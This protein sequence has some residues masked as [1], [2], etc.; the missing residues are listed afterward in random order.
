[1]STLTA[2]LVGTCG[3]WGLVW[4]AI[5]PSKEEGVLQP[6][7]REKTQSS[8]GSWE[9]APAAF[10]LFGPWG[11]GE[12]ASSLCKPYP[13]GRAGF[14]WRRGSGGNILWQTS[15]WGGR[16]C[17]A[18]WGLQRTLWKDWRKAQR[19]E[20]ESGAKMHKTTQEW[21]HAILS[22][23]AYIL[24]GSQVSQMRSRKLRG[25]VVPNRTLASGSGPVLLQEGLGLME[26]SAALESCHLPATQC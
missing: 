24:G 9:D 12:R 26:A 4:G 16:S 19:W 14:E 7:T 23:R 2:H 17:T 1:M 3:H 20:D 18:E 6:N 25:L 11:Q 15:V 21:E 10:H 22:R 13:W 8:G 5:K